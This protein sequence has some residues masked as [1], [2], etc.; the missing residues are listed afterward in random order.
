MVKIRKPFQGVLNIFRF[1]WHFYLMSIG[2]ISIIFILNLI[3][4]APYHLFG[5]IAIFIIIT[6]TLISLLVSYYVYDM[7]VLYKLKWLDQLAIPSNGNMLN[8]NAGFDETSV[9]LK[10][11]Y[12]ELELIVF[13]FYNPSQHTELSIKR[14]RKAYPPFPGTQQVSQ[15]KFPLPEYYADYIFVILSAHEIRSVSERIVFFKELNRVLKQKGKIVVTEHLKDFQNFLAY[16]IGFFHFVSKS[17]WK[18]AFKNS[19]LKTVL[20]IKI[21]PFIT[22]FVLEKNGI[23]S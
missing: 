1:N 20:E 2:L 8:I 11:K 17:S 6:S 22:T 21:T 12:P 19:N 7:S 9:L 3:L 23:E 10:E 5:H 13:D 18:N 4:K 16:N 15:Y 14:A